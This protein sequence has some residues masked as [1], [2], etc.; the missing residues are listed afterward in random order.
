MLELDHW[1]GSLVGLIGLGFVGYSLVIAE[2]SAHNPRIAANAA[3][4]QANAAIEANKASLETLH[5][6]QR[7]WVS[8]ETLEV[9]HPPAT[10]I[11]NRP[12]HFEFVT[13]AVLKNTENS[14][15]LRG[16]R[17]SHRP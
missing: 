7:P 8:A 9:I 3:K 6:T 5:L 14:I 15:A 1:V 4:R 17:V 16:L 10:V 12:D 11:S 13:G 2:E